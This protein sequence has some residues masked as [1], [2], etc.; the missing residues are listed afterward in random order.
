MP[1]DLKMQRLYDRAELVA[2]IGDPQLNRFCVMSFV[3]FMAGEWFGDRPKT[4]SPVI[5]KFVIPLNDRVDA[6]TRQRLKPFAPRIIGTNDGEDSARADLIFRTIVAK[7]VPAAL[8]DL[9]ERHDTNPAATGA[10]VAPSPDL[11]PAEIRLAAARLPQRVR[12]NLDHILEARAAGR[13]DVLAKEAGHLIATLAEGAGDAARRT[14]YL[15]TALDLLDRLCDIRVRE[16]IPAGDV[17]HRSAGGAALA[18]R[19]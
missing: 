19:G 1:L 4:A 6:K 2:G 13:F 16:P 5:R 17:T 18:G 10:A 3:A 11:A 8:A 15:N 9:S 14:W 12:R 7:V